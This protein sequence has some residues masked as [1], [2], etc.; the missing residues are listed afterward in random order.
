[1]VGARP[2]EVRAL[3]TL[4]CDVAYLGDPTSGIVHLREARELGR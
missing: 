2:A 4:G 3:A 1:M